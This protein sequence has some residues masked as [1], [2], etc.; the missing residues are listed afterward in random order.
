MKINIFQVD[1]FTNNPFNGNPACVV[2]LKKWLPDDILLKIASENSVPETAFFINKSDYVELRWFTPDLEID[3]CGHATLATAHILKTIYNY[4]H[5]QIIFNTMSGT[6]KVSYKKNFYFLDFPSR[7]P[8]PSD[9]PKEINLS[10]NIKPKEVLKSRD[11]LLVYDSQDEIEKI[12]INK[13]Y[14]DKINLGHGGVIVSSLSS[15]V[16]FVSR[17]FTP[18]ATILEDFVTGSSHCSLI[19][20]WA[21]RLKKNHLEAIQLSN[22]PGKLICINKNDRVII[23]GQAVIYSKGEFYI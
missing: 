1:A 13:H 10:L 14:F 2:P 23:G 7:L 5:S 17:F 4:P 22:R 6:L 16:D 18:Q 11:F 9:L 12:K 8:T 15:E 19:P 20:F 3:L 21:M